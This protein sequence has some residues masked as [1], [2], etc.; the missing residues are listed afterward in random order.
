MCTH[1]NFGYTSVVRDEDLISLPLLPYLI[2]ENLTTLSLYCNINCAV[3]TRVPA[4]VP[5]WRSEDK[6]GDQ[7]SLSIMWTWD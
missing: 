1:Q 7:F 3:H 6:V 2:F 4:A 5:V